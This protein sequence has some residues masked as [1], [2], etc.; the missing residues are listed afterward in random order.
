MQPSEIT[1]PEIERI[2]T[3]LR[4][5]TH[6]GS[7]R[8]FAIGADILVKPGSIGYAAIVGYGIAAGLPRALATC[9]HHV[10]SRTG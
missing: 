1:A 3:K 6:D 5:E 7:L 8:C 10:P 4:R 9:R 2:D